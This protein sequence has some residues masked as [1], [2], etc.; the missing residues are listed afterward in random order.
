MH[1]RIRAKVVTTAKDLDG[2]TGEWPDQPLSLARS[3]HHPGPVSSTEILRQ[4]GGRSPTCVSCQFSRVSLS[5]K[6]F[7]ATLLPNKTKRQSAFVRSVRHITN[8]KVAAQNR[9]CDHDGRLAPRCLR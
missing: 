3:Y 5:N 1:P 9:N 6:P 2:D 8:P 7:F 4:A